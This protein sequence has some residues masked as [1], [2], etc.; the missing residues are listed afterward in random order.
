MSLEGLKN[1]KKVQEILLIGI[2]SIIYQYIIL[3]IKSYQVVLRDNFDNT[4][5]YIDL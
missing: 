1:L 5:N 3:I 4:L 2:W